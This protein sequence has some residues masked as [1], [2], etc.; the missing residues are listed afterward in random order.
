VTKALYDAGRNAHLLGQIAFLADTFKWVLV[1]AADYTLSLGTHQFLSDIP[2]PARVAT[3]PALANKTA[4]AGVADADDVVI[5]AATGDQAEA[6]V[7]IKDT[8]SAATS[9]LILYTDEGTGL[10]VQP[11]GGDIT[12]VHDNTAGIKI[13]KL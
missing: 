8:G 5:T 4:V 9:P 7:L 13:Y 1:D 10:P 3:S 2:A 6:A 12:I 11:N